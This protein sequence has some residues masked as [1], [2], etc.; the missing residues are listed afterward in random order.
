MTVSIPLYDLLT[1]KTGL[2]SPGGFQMRKRPERFR[3]G[4]SPVSDGRQRLGAGG[5]THAGDDIVE[6]GLDGRTKGRHGRNDDDGD[7]GGDQAVL[8]R[9]GTRLVG[10]E[11]RN[12]LGHWIFP[13]DGVKRAIE[14]GGSR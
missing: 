6:L 11:F 7:E 1:V 12:K 14:N 4:P 10:H 5:A 2:P 8:D 3:S 9:G 13:L